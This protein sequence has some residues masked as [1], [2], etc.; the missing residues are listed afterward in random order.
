MSIFLHTTEGVDAKRLVYQALNPFCIRR[1]KNEVLELPPAHNGELMVR[2]SP[3]ETE[4][5][6][7]LFDYFRG[8]VAK[9]VQRLQELRGEKGY[10]NG[11]RQRNLRERRANARMSIMV[12]LE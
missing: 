2:L 1:R 6:D 9:Y 8:R 11:D 5:Y 4:F 10:D 7:A 3:L 12:N